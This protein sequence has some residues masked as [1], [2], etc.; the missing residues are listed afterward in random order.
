MIPVS[1]FAD[2][3]MVLDN[4]DFVPM[5]LFFRHSIHFFWGIGTQFA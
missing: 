1:V 5:P 2:W 4:V 3:C